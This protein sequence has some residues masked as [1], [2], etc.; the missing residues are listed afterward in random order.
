MYNRRMELAL[1]PSVLPPSLAN[2][3][4]KPEDKKQ[5]IAK[6]R[7]SHDSMIDQIIANPWVSQGELAKIYGY[8]EGWVSQVISSDAFQGRLAERKNQIIDPTLRMTVEEGFKAM[9][10]SSLRILLDRLNQPDNKVSDETALKAAEIAAKALGMGAKG[11]GVTVNNSF[12]VAVPQ[13]AASSEDWARQNGAGGQ[14]V[15]T[16]PA[17]RTFDGESVAT[18]VL[19]GSTSSA[20]AI[21]TQ[22]LLAALKS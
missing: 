10:K 5:A 16:P 13:K 1:P 19:V 8:T 22:Q 3:A 20:P 9:A 17:G 12:V 15:S 6:I 2:F 18:A 4:A 7:Y 21:N 11:V 14:S